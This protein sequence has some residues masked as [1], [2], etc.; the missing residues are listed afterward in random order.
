MI[1]CRSIHWKKTSFKKY[2]ITPLASIAILWWDYKS[3]D[4]ATIAQKI[5]R[6]YGNIMRR[7]FGN[8]LTTACRFTLHGTLSLVSRQRIESDWHSHNHSKT[9]VLEKFNCKKYQVKRDSPMQ[10]LFRSYLLS[11][12]NLTRFQLISIIVCRLLISRRKMFDFA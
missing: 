4:A 9:N 12:K 7:F 11:S 5:F 10:S 3:K 1:Y 8:I 6:Y 2:V